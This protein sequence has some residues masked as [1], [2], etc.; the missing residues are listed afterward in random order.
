MKSSN[1]ALA[2]ARYAFAPN[3]YRYCGPDTQGEL[4]EY[5]DRDLTDPGLVAHLQGFEVMY[6]YLEAIALANGIA[7]PLDFR[8]VEAYWVGNGL[9]AKVTR[10]NVYLALTDKQHVQRKIP[11]SEWKWLLPKIDQQAYLH[12]SFHVLNV[13]TRTG[14]H[15]VQHTVE[16]MDSCRISWGTITNNSKRKTKNHVL[17][18]KSQRLVYENGR[19]YLTPAVREAVIPGEMLPK[20]LKPGDLVSVHWGF[21]CDVLTEA[22]VQRLE[23]Y[24]RH[25]LRLANQTI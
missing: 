17:K 9:L 13:F 4:G 23:K 10:Q 2:C 20:R 6:P 21:V 7:D 8:V 24:T 1:G 5:I 18:L 3:W 16:T 22:Q 25:H 15:S 19:L 12:H 14:H 11:R